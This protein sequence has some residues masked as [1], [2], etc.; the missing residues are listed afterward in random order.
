[1]RYDINENT[2]ILGSFSTGDTVTIDVYRISDGVKVMDSVLCSEVG[3]TGVFSYLFSQ[4][5]TEKTEYLWIMNNG[6]IDNRG[7][8][9]LGGYISFVVLQIDEL[10][11]L[12]GLK[13]GSPMTV[14]KETRTVEDIDLT[15]TEGAND[16]VTV[17]RQ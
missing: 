8:I 10:H 12:Q 15:I 1:M 2:Y 9:V 14:T 17:E 11:K 6:S 7:K 3:G 5:I 4:T 13:A 16:E